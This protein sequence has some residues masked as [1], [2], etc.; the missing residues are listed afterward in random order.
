QFMPGTWPSWSQDD[1]HNGQVSPFDVGD[2][3][4]AQGRYMCALAAQMAQALAAGRVQGSLRDLILAAYNAG[5]AGVLAAG[6]VPRS[7]ETDGY[8]SRINAALARVGTASQPGVGPGAGLVPNDGS[9]ASN[10]VLAGQRWLGQRYVW[11]G[12]D[13]NG[14][15]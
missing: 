10:V 13:P 1:D 11:G 9:F 4:M 12:G 7:G 15:T 3:V 6:G 8:V 14:P 5:P 2:A